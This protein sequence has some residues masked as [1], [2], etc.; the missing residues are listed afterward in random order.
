MSFDKKR[1]YELLPAL[2]RIRDA[3]IALK[4]QKGSSVSGEPTIEGP[5]EALISIIAD[6]IAGL[7]ENLDQLYD[8][9]F[10]ETC[11]EWVV[12][13]IGDLVGTRQLTEI[14]GSSISQR[15][16]VAN[17]I[18][19]RRRKGTA[20][21]I[22]QLARDVT[23]WD[24]NVVE[25]F[26]RL[27]T[28]QYL[29]HL[30]PQNQSVAGLRNW[31]TLEYANT[32]FDN[33]PKTAD[34]RRIESGRGKYNIPNIGIFLWRIKNYSLTLAPPYQLD[35]VR[36]KFNVLGIDTPLFH[37]PSSEETITQ[38]A[39]PLNVPMP[40]SRRLLWEELNTFYGGN[41]SLVIYINGEEL[42]PS[43]YNTHFNPFP[44]PP[45][46][47]LEEIITACDLSDEFDGF[48]TFIGWN[49]V[50]TE[51]IA[52]DPVLGRI[53]F[54]DALI[55]ALAGLEVQLLHHYGFSAAMGGGEYERENSFQS[56]LV[57][58]IQVE[59]GVLTI[60]NAINQL[61]ATGGVIEIIDNE[62]Y[63]EDLRIP[64]SEGN[65]LEI[66]AANGK[67]PMLVL[68]NAIE[69]DAEE[70]TQVYFNGL[71]IG[72]GH[73]DIPTSSRLESLEIN[74]C[75]FVPGAL[76][77]IAI[78]AAS[79]AAPRIIVASIFTEIRIKKSILGSLRI[80]DGAKVTVEDSIL[81]ATDKSQMVYSSLSE[82]DPGGQLTIQNSTIIG[83]VNTQIMKEASNTI[84]LAEEGQVRAE[85]LQVGCVRFSYFPPNSRLP[86]A[87]RCQPELSGNLARIKPQ[88]T[89]LQFGAPG[90]GQLSEHCVKEITQGADDEAE[91]GAFHHL[92]Q[93]Q[94]LSNLRIRL[95]E[96]LRFGL[97]AGIFYAS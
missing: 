13:Y 53:A 16:E 74:H 69:I 45:V 61:V 51:K 92:Y 47:N 81:D 76:P 85:R 5:L 14:P 21:V 34:V 25:F 54:P 10:I 7:E 2:Y 67:R 32:P 17:T 90:Y 4:V 60:Q 29:N 40:I 97:E 66:R 3:E 89:S 80:I 38:L 41:K 27:A 55:P 77:A 62:Y 31:K 58:I 86:K 22:E 18:K 79:P 94:K 46:T 33:I 84:F 19:Y 8:D 56:E 91:M 23:G 93:A 24:A 70:N 48:G 83:G 59:A 20:S 39:G 72:G 15:S 43:T 71:L 78:I 64:L 63:F 26:Q 75:T 68:N 9:Q 37:L 87:Y 35:D 6:E 65:S 96:Y 49:N 1:L 11:A 88:F 73:I 28:S 44:N 82:L 50:P 95:N 57:P 52:I 12:P 42:N 30:R 36:Y